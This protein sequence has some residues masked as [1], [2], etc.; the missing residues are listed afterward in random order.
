[1]SFHDQDLHGRR[2]AEPSTRDERTGGIAVPCRRSKR[3]PKLRVSWEHRVRLFGQWAS[4]RILAANM[5]ETR[6]PFSPESSFGPILEQ[7]WYR[8]NPLEL[9]KGD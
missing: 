8:C 9:G 6:P 4:I 7:C 3:P 5:A 2:R 1:M